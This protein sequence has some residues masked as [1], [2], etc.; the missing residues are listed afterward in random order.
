MTDWNSTQYTKFEKE[1]TQPSIDLISRIGISPKSILDIGCGPGNSTNQLRMHFPSSDIIGVDSSDNMLDR[2]SRAYPDLRFIKCSIPND[3]DALEKFDLIFSNACLH[4]I[5]N[6]ESLLPSLMDKLNDGG[7]LA[8]Q[9]PLV[10]NAMFYKLLDKL[11]S[12]EKWKQLRTI[13]NFHN[14]SPSETYDI[15]SRIATN[16]TMWDTT[17]YHIVSSHNAVLDWYKGTGLKPYLDALNSCEK[18]EFLSE[19]LEMIKSNYPVQAD[20]NIILKM[21]R[22]F[23]ISVK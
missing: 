3:L 2:A 22:L 20:G 19:L 10:Q 14:L 4:W 8:V 13:K 11:I 15:L 6:H 9:M 1:R 5:P 12:N 16:V 7:A 23:F 18:N 21:P 17:Y